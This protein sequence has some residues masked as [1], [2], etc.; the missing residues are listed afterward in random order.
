[1]QMSALCVGSDVL[2]L[3]HWLIHC[4]AFM[5]KAVLLFWGGMALSVKYWTAYRAKFDAIRENAV[6]TS[7]ILKLK[8]HQI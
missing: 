8:M 4:V 1:M 7:Q 2:N 6:M 5:A 3:T